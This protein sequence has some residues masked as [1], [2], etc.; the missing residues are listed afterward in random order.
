MFGQSIKLKPPRADNTNYKGTL[1][2]N[3]TEFPAN[4]EPMLDYI[5]DD[6][7]A[8]T[9]TNQNYI[10]DVTDVLE[11]MDTKNTNPMRNTKEE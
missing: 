10:I 5:F 3:T 6:E 4:T 11:M 2:N 8:S 7:Y 1:K 9:S